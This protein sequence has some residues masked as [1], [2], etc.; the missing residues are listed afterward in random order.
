MNAEFTDFILAAVISNEGVLWRTDNGWQHSGD[1]VDVAFRSLAYK[2]G[3]EP[4]FFKDQ[5]E[6]V[7]MIPYESERKFSGVFYKQN[8]K[9]HFAMKGAV[10]TVAEKII[11]SRSKRHPGRIRT[12]GSTGISG[13]GPRFGTKLQIQMSHIYRH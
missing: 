9:L 4:K 10:E 5:V 6:V 7:K 3:K 11:G 13:T 8:G 12:N 1:A 2:I